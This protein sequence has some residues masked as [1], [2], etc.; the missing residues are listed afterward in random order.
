MLIYLVLFAFVS[1][2][3][4]AIQ[5]NS[6]CALEPKDKRQLVCQCSKKLHLLCIFNVDIKEIAAKDLD[7]SLT[8]VF[9]EDVALSRQ[10][11]VDPDNSRFD[12][13]VNFE[14]NFRSAKKKIYLY[15][16]NF[17]VLNA[18]FNRI[19]FLN[20]IFIPSFAFYEKTTFLQEYEARKSEEN[21]REVAPHKF[22]ST[23]V[24]ELPELYDFGIDRF[25]FYG[26]STEML[27]LEGPFDQINV[28]EKAF[29]NANI[30]E[31]NIGCYCLEC[32][33]LVRECRINFNQASGQETQSFD[34]KYLSGRR[35]FALL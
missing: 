6:S 11:S 17:N 3:L 25:A 27:I 33:K 30:D 7:R 29:F 12:V 4:A 19:Y 34:D 13:N 18:A 15:F 26:L 22:I 28:H 8:P 14:A 23:A 20:F 5:S 2:E 16:P 10:H 9:Y 31:L 32:E 1:Q 24:F 35:I 21:V